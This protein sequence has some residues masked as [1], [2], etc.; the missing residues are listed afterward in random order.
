MLITVIDLHSFLGLFRRMEWLPR[1][2][3]GTLHADAPVRGRALFN[4]YTQLTPTQRTIVA[5]GIARGMK[6]LQG[7]FTIIHRDFTPHNVLLDDQFRPL[8]SDLGLTPVEPRLPC[9]ILIESVSMALECLRPDAPPTH[10]PAEDGPLFVCHDRVRSAHEGTRVVPRD[11]SL[12]RSR[13]AIRRNQGPESHR[14]V[15]LPST[16]GEDSEWLSEPC[17]QDPAGRP[18]FSR[19]CALVGQGAHWCEG[20]DKEEFDGYKRSVDTGEAAEAAKD[21]FVDGRA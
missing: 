1:L 8:I 19:I 10:R 17:A 3:P 11:Q 4:H 21:E 5:Y 9:A 14:P 13:L 7:K 18:S 20:T 2:P 16:R 6:P 15:I 12:W